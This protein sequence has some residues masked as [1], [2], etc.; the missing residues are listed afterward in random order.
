MSRR[1]PVIIAFFAVLLVGVTGAQAAPGGVGYIKDGQVWVAKLDGTK[2]VQMS[3]GDAWWNDVGQSSTG[4]IVATKNEP[5]KIAQL[6]TFTVWNADGSEK[7]FGPASPGSNFAGASLA[8]PLGLELTASN[9][10]L[11][12]G[13]SSYVYGY[14]VGSLTTGYALL[15]SATRSTPTSTFTNTL[16]DWPSLAAGR[17][18]GSPDGHTI[19]VEDPGGNNTSNFTAWTGPNMAITGVPNGTVHR[20]QASDDGKV[21]GFEVDVHDGN[22]PAADDSRVLLM[23]TSGLLGTYVDDC[24]LPTSGKA[25]AVD[26]SA[27]G[28]E[29]AW[30]DADGVK[31][32]GPPDFTGPANCLLTRAPALIE[33]GARHPALGPID[34]DA[35][36]AARNPV[37][38]TTPTTPTPTTTTPT[39]PTLKTPAPGAAPALAVPT[40]LSAAKLTGSKGTTL[41]VAVGKAGKVS[42][43]VT[44]SAKSVGRKG[45]AIVI[46]TGTAKRTKA[47]A[48]TIRVKRTA[49]GKRY[50]KKLKGK[51]VKVIVRSGGKTTTKTI[52]LK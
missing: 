47:G 23:K 3:S 21:L 51:R 33:A 18:I 48:F 25:P 30:E 5:G 22:N 45:K 31:I 41:T 6:T 36:Y 20:V 7:D 12:Y 1:V 28:T 14:P 24:W 8:A 46:A 37:T 39:T 15:P 29:I 34:V 38:T 16:I 19:S 10:L 49:A 50:A 27:D 52:K 43:S 35:L 26:I 44:V 40:G 2:K 11:I 13:F 42:V 17:I 4:G 9:G 32:S